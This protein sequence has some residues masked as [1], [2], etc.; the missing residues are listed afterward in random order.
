[1]E[2]DLGQV[3]NELKEDVTT[4]VELK[5]ELLKLNTYERAGKVVGLLSYGVVILILAFMGTLFLFLALAIYLGNVLD[6]TTA[7][8]IIVAG[9]YLVIL[10]LLLMSRKWFSK[11]IAGIVINALSDD[12]ND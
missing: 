4:Y 5:L 10:G 6:S 3:F 9:I 12:K 8:F 7:G 2:K 1:M 11:T